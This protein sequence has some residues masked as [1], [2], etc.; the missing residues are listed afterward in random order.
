MGTYLLTNRLGPGTWAGCAWTTSQGTSRGSGQSRAADCYIEGSNPS[1]GSVHN[2]AYIGSRLSDQDQLAATLNRGVGQEAQLDF[3]TVRA[4]PNQVTL[5]QIQI[6]RDLF[7]RKQFSRRSLES[8]APTLFL[9]I[10]LKDL[11]SVRSLVQADGLRT[12]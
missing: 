1:P 11:Q 9:V 4:A 2:V 3:E 5:V 12:Q 7:S 10:W 6:G 8:L